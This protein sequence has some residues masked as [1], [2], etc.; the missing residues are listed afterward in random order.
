VTPTIAKNMTEMM[1]QLAVLGLIVLI[2]FIAMMLTVTIMSMRDKAMRKLLRKRREKEREEQELPDLTV[3]L[4]QLSRDELRDFA[5]EEKKRAFEQGEQVHVDVID[6]LPLKPTVY[7]DPV[8]DA[9]KPDDPK[10]KPK[11]VHSFLSTGALPKEDEAAEEKGE[12]DSG[13]EGD[14]EGIA[15]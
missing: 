4:P 10:P 11:I 3:V 2:A 7:F 5:V 1:R 6:G 9:A 14:E 12:D 13:P 8:A 15:H